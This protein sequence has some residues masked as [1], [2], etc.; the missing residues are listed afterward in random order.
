MNVT[1]M[2][3]V[4]KNVAHSF[5]CK[6]IALKER[7]DLVMKTVASQDRIK[8]GKV[9]LYNELSKA[10][11]ISELHQREVQFTSQSN[12]QHLE[13]LLEV[14]MHGVQCLLSLMFNKPFVSLEDLNLD[15]YE[16]LVYIA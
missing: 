9:K 10:D 4:L 16:I 14:E 7:V 12:K 3:I 11:I 6:T 2:H 5:N 1:S 15:N 13:S 8:Q